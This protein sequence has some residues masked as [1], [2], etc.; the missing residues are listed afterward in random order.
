MKCMK[1]KQ[2]SVIKL[3]NSNV[4][5]CKNH[6][7]RYFEKKV[8]RTVRT[9]N[10]VEKKDRIAIAVSGGK[11][12]SSLLY[13]MNLIASQKRDISLV[14]ITINEG[15]KGYKE[16]TIEDLKKI[17]KDY[18]IELKIISYKKEFGYTLD[19][20]VK[21]L[22]IKPCTACGVLRRYLLNKTARELKAN[23]LATGHNLDDEAQAILMNQFKR[24]I[25]LT[26][27][28][29]PITG[30][31]RT[32]H[33]I[34][35]IKPLYLV[36]EKETIIYANL[37]NLIKKSVECPYASESFRS[38]VRKFLNEWEEKYPGTKHSIVKAF[39]DILP[40]L[41]ERYKTIRKI[42]LCKKCSEPCSQEVC[43]A[44]EILEKL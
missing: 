7:I 42:N 2:K 31:I 20:I 23:K 34:P 24:N 29:G 10:L 37:K 17:C 44:C 12:S 43:T 18:K 26:A 4:Y 22:K 14:A 32:K 5:L 1:C 25:A 38:D 8:L 16:K 41:K 30:I 28:L 21:K 33:F 15:I 27:R 9:F 19:E 3:P 36:T 11:D 39:L 40:L 6:F 13:L 35:R